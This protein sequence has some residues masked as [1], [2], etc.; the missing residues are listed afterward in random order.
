MGTKPLHLLMPDMAVFVRVV[1]R[2]SFSAAARDLGM[3]PSAVSRQLAR[4][5]REMGIRLLERTTRRLR[6]SEAGEGAFRRCR[7]MVAA[8]Q[9]ALDLAEVAMQE[10]QGLIRVSMPKAFGRHLVQPLVPGFLARYPG[11]QLQLGV[12]DLPVD[13]VGD[14]FDLVIRITDSPPAHL[15]GRPL[16]R[17]GQLLCATPDYLAVRGVPRHPLEL[18]R[19]DCIPLGEHP[20]D[21]RWAFRRDGEE[22]VVPIRG[23]YLNNHSEMRLDAVLHHLGIAC[24][25]HFVARPFLESGRIV[26]VLPEWELEVAYRGMAWVLYPPNRQLAPKLRAF[27]DHLAAGLAAQGEDAAAAPAPGSGPACLP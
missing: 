1:E 23:R 9:A 26:R 17:V 16:V 7:D 6:L 20:G 22:T 25:S 19:H 15:A 13:P 8:A 2:G 24:V 5:E 27:I 14:D 21:K 18:V 4:L 3:T 12:T 10:P 11:V